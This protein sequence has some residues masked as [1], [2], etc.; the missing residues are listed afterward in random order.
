M[1]AA[2]GAAQR[3]A[4]LILL[5]LPAQ[6]W[7]QAT[8][9]HTTSA[10]TSHVLVR[11]PAGAFIM[12]SADGKLDE[13]PPHRVFLDDYY[14]DRFEVTNQLF[15]AFL[16]YVGSH[17]D[18]NGHLLVDVFD[19]DA[20]IRPRS[21]GGYRVAQDGS[22]EH[23][24]GEISWFGAQAYCDWA[25]LRLPTEAMWE[26]AARGTDG[27]TYPWGE[28]IDRERANYGKDGCCGADP[29]DGFTTASPV[30]SFDMGTSPYGV[31][32]MAGNVWEFVSDWYGESYYEASPANNPEGPETGLSRVL[33]GG[34]FTSAPR[35][36]RTTD[37]SG[38]PES[39]SY[40]QIGFRCAA[41][42]AELPAT[43]I[44]DGS[45][46]V[47]KQTGSRKKGQ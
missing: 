14:I 16:N 5:V 21:Q 9:T 43:L 39:L 35:R 44:E 18:E 28:D 11:V 37:R 33:R 23:P 17:L 6:T 10:A 1:A 27:R 42:T 36:L 31:H 4:L 19:P 30:G 29:A 47:L 40:V 41:T 45:W 2:C 34:S 46:G 20:E 26:K 12:G 15:V 7:A 25:G 22:A 32:D 38:L 13:Q 3:I 8:H 24:A